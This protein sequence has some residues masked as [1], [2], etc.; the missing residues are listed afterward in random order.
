MAEGKDPAPSSWFAVEFGSYLK[1]AFKEVSGLSHEAE[2]VTQYSTS[3]KQITAIVPGTLKWGDI[4]LKRVMTSDLALWEWRKVVEDGDMAKARA[5]GTITLYDTA[6]KAAAKW[7][8]LNAW[9][10]KVSG[11]LPNASANQPAM[12]ELTIVCEGFNRSQ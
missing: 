5:N 7:D 9:P 1:G 2:A 3:G 6:G 10:S 4:T 12:E 8:I 11:P